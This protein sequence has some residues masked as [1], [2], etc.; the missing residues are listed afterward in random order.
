MDYIP[1]TWSTH[2]LSKVSITPSIIHLD[3]LRLYL[4]NLNLWVVL[5]LYIK[6]IPDEVLDMDL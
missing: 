6:V 1:R 5:V 3:G 2:A 4:L